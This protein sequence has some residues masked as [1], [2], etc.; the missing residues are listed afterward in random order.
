MTKLFYIY[1]LMNVYK[2]K[3]LKKYT[4]ITR[5]Q[6]QSIWK[7]GSNRVQ[8]TCNLRSCAHSKREPITNRPENMGSLQ[9]Y[10]GHQLDGWAVQVRRGCPPQR[11]VREAVGKRS[12]LLQGRARVRLGPAQ[13]GHSRQIGRQPWNHGSVNLWIE[14]CRLYIFL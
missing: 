7:N 9:L 12:A 4:Q 6:I 3:L 13:N 2:L 11:L 1:I 14:R 10:P 5:K 8:C